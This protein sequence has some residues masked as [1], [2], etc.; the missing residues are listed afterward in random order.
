MQFYS[1]NVESETTESV[2]LALEPD[3]SLVPID[4]YHILLNKGLRLQEGSKHWIL[5]VGDGRVVR[6]EKIDNQL[7]LGYIGE[8][9]DCVYI[10]LISSDFLN[11]HVN[12]ERTS[13]T[14]GKDA[15]KVLHSAAISA[16]K[17][18]L[19]PYIDQVR[20]RQA[21][22]TLRIIHENP[23]FLAV[24]SDVRAFV[25][26]N[27]SLNAK[28]E[29]D[30]FVELARQR[31]RKQR[32]TRREIRALET[33][34]GEDVDARVQKIA[35]AIN[36]DK[37]ASLADY[38]VK[39]KE[40]LDLLDSSLAYADPEERNYLKEEFVHDLIIPIRSDSEDLN[41]EDHNLWILDDRLAFYSYL[42]SDKP[43]R[44][45]LT[46]SDSGREPDI[47]VVFDRSLAF[48]REGTSEP[49]I[50]VEFKRPGRTSYTHDDNPVT[51]VLEYVAIM[52]NGGS[53]KDKSG[54]VRKSISADT[55]F[56]CF[57]VADFTPK[58]IEMV[59]VSIAQNKSADG[60]GYFGFSPI[61]NAVVE[62]LPY[63]KLLHDARIRNE[64]FFAKLGLT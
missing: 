36:V 23:Q 26:E 10:G 49:I 30:I 63:S 22:T 12:Q 33:A 48:D 52:R 46:D 45:F 53:F 20:V 28:S 6:D 32:E 1:E 38:V 35:S 15:Y 47:A 55:R 37:K 43:F 16:A 62:V 7:G 19:S 60:E 31:R 64:A 51:Q 34:T 41:Y 14:F 50:I 13:F 5:Y 59:S 8:N 40:I 58:L 17:R 39:R 44:T 61:H 3:G 11:S 27:L 57:V 25:D 2:E 56:I 42:K 54:R 9:G 4:I 24:A 29:E 21:E 18:H